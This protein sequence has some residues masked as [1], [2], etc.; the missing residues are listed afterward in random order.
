[1]MT[2]KVE[3]AKTF[4]WQGYLHHFLC[5]PQKDKADPE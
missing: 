3:T 2:Y 5:A 1:M 4:L